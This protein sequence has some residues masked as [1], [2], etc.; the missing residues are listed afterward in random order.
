MV[1]RQLVLSTES[2]SGRAWMPYIA[3][4]GQEFRLDGPQPRR[5]SDASVGLLLAIALIICV[6]GAYL[7]MRMV[8]GSYSQGA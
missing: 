2:S 7:G 4:S 8:S 5:R 6:G 3:S 1:C